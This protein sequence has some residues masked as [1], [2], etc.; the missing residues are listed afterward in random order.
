MSTVC[1]KYLDEALDGQL[2]PSRAWSRVS[3]DDVAVLKQYAIVGLL[4]ASEI[5]ETILD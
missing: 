4:V 5:A 3:P 1:G 2:K